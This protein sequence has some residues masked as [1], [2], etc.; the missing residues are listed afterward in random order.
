MA[1]L[2]DRFRARSNAIGALRLLLACAVVV[3]HTWQLERAGLPLGYDW[4]RGQA[5]LGVLA[6]YGFFLLSGYLITA[7]ATSVTVPRYLWHRFLRIFPGFWVCLLVVA[8]VVAPVIALRERG[9]VAG[10]FSAPDGPWHYVVGNWTTGIRVQGIDGLVNGAALDAPLW[11]LSYELLAYILVATLAAT[12]VLRQVPRIV[13][14]L[15][16]A[17][18]AWLAWDFATHPATLDAA[19]NSIGMAKHGGLGPFPLVGAFDVSH[20]ILLGF[21]FLLGAAA[22]LYGRRVPMHAGIAVTAAL[23][24]MATAH[25]G[26]FFVLGVPA[27]AYVVLYAAASA[28]ALLHRIGTR[29]DFSYGVYIYGWPWQIVLLTFG[30]P[31]H[32]VW[33][34][35]IAS[36]AGATVLGAASWYLVERKAI[37]LK[38]I[39]AAP[40]N[41]LPRQSVPGEAANREAVV[42]GRP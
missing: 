28:P 24:A 25:Y 4:S 22:R 2:A 20:L 33:W 41:R 13:L 27:F 26:G 10:L 40:S 3:S 15:L 34:Y 36:L 7:S 37:A 29:S 35:L 31:R 11:S 38:H 1:C 42:S 12:G 9:S 32:G 16:G 8:F 19:G 14:V 18:F 6:V 5:D 21:I 23:V 39:W 17:G 30:V